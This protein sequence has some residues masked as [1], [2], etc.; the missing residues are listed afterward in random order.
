MVDAAAL[1]CRKSRGMAVRCD[2][3]VATGAG[4][5]R[6][7]P[8]RFFGP[9][10]SPYVA[11]YRGHGAASRL[12]AGSRVRGGGCQQDLLRAGLFSARVRAIHD[13][14][15]G[16]RASRIRRDRRTGELEVCLGRGCSDQG[17]PARA[18]LRGG[19]SSAPDCSPRHQPGAAQHRPVGAFPGARSARNAIRGTGGP[20]GGCRRR[21][22]SPGIERKRARCT[23]GLA[24]LC[25]TAGGRGLCAPLRL[26][27]ALRNA[28]RC[29]AHAG[30]AC[31]P[32]S[33]HAEWSSPSGPCATVPR[34]S[35]M[36]T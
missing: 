23:A 7:D 31:G 20:G 27:P 15:D 34:A 22:R 16:R 3:A 29:G 8:A 10:P 1:E 33:L 28:A 14:G 4:D 35:A 13:L 18:G 2:A 36:A 11:A 30:S 26:D 9:C 25:R 21:A 5:H 17:G 12:V 32:V 24:G 6:G 19:S